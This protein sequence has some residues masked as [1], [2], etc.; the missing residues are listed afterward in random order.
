MVLSESESGN[1]WETNNPEGA[2]RT[3]E[4]TLQAGAGGVWGKWSFK[5]VLPFLITLGIGCESH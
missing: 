5:K 4:G 1:S 2:S 3:L